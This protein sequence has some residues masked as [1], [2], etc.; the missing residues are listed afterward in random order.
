MAALM[1]VIAPSGV[2]HQSVSGPACSSRPTAFQLPAA[3][4]SRARGKND[5]SGPAEPESERTRSLSVC[6]LTHRHICSLSRAACYWLTAAPPFMMT[7]S[8]QYYGL[9]LKYISQT[10]GAPWGFSSFLLS[11][12]TVSV[13]RKRQMTKRMVSWWLSYL[14]WL[15]TIIPKSVTRGM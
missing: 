7:L 13:F 4:S 6:F 10:E 14:I 3:K 11:H 5:S 1:S 12:L 9:K 2:S 8:E 15:L